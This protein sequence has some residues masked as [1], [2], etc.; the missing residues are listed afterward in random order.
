[1]GWLF[2]LCCFQTGRAKK[3]KAHS[4]GGFI[5]ITTQILT[6]YDPEIKHI[7]PLEI[8]WKIICP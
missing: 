7:M 3:R 5:P 4:P 6:L 2:S 1:M 8:G